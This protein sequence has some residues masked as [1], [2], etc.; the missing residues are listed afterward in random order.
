MLAA[1]QKPINR[2]QEAQAQGDEQEALSDEADQTTRHTNER[3]TKILGR[4][5]E[6][7]G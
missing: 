3:D 1:V 4:K 5:R 6:I 7:V 2:T